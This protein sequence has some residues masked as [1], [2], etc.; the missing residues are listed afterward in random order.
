MRISQRRGQLK[1]LDDMNTIQTSEYDI[2]FVSSALEVANQIPVSSYDQIAFLC[3][4]NTRHHCYSLLRSH[5]PNVP[6]ITIPEGEKHKNLETCQQVWEDMFRLQLSRNSLLMNMGGG[7]V[8][9]LGGFVASTYKRGINFI[10]IP[11]TL[12]AMVDATVGGKTGIDFQHIKNGIG[13]FSNPQQVIVY[14]GFLKTLP[15]TECLSGFAEML[16]HG[17]LADEAHLNKLMDNGFKP[18]AN[19][20]ATVERSIQIKL[21]IVAQ[22][23]FEQGLRKVLNLGHTIGHALESYCLQ[24]HQPI[25][26]GHAV[27]LGIIAELWLSVELCGFPQD[28]SESVNKY[29]AALY[30]DTLNIDIAIDN[31]AS[32]AGNDKKNR[33][34]ALNFSLLKNVGQPV[35]DVE[36]SPEL[37]SR[38]VEHLKQHV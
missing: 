25:P 22:D 16:K 33:E 2:T 29:L 19:D 31:L 10:N 36:V 17:L 30:G 5:F 28:K 4:S 37:F 9:D 13:L 34:K 15:E 1:M 20:T 27:A 11:T 38:A 12:L 21:D 23:P 6:V 18:L 3:D 32:F 7:M 24:Q 14:P 8:S 35:F 26:H